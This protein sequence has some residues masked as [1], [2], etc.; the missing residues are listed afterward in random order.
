MSSLTNQQVN[1]SYQGLIKLADS[2]TGITSSVQ[3]VQ[4]GLGNNT[5]LLIGTDYLGGSSL[6]P[7]YPTQRQKGGA[8]I[9]TGAGTAMNAGSHGLVQSVLFYDKGNIS[10]SSITFAIGTISSTQD[11]YEFAIYDGQ[12]CPTAGFQPKIRLTAPLSA[13][14]ADT[15]TTGLYTY[16]FSSDLVIEKGG[17]YFLLFRVTNPGAVAPTTRFRN[18]LNT[19]ESAQFANNM[20]GVVLDYGGTCFPNVFRAG[21]GSAVGQLYGGLSSPLQASYSVNDMENGVSSTNQSLGGFVLN[22]VI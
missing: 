17:F 20:L 12:V 4:D 8:G 2:S 15:T 5:G 22:P 9:A 18:P 1:Q 14:S 19:I 16:A 10:Y 13:T 7:V 11:T 6:V 21:T 3:A